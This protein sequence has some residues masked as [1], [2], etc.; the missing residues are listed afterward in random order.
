LPTPALADEILTPGEGQVR[1]LFCNGGN[2][3][4]AVPDQ[5]KLVTALKSLELLVVLD[6]RMTA[7]ARLAHY[8]F[9][10]KLSMEE[11]DYT[12][13]QEFFGHFPFAQYSPA[14]IQP[15]FDVIDEWE[16]FWGMAHR[17]RVPMSLG[18]SNLG[19]RPVPG[20]PV[21]IE[22]KP[23]TDELMEIEAG[24]ARIP[25]SQVKQYPG[26]QIFEEAWATVAPRG[27]DAAGRF[28]L[29]PGLFLEDLRRVHAEPVTSSGAYREDE[30]FTHRLISR[31]MREVYN[32][33]GVHLAAL[34][35]KGPGN[36]AY[37]NPDDMR[38]AGIKSG[39]MVEIESSHGRIVAIARAEDGLRKG[40][41]SMS[42]SWGDLPEYESQDAPQG[43][44]C[45]NR[46]I[47]DDSDFEP[48]VGM[49][50]QSA[51]PVNVRRPV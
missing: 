25:L 2:L 50:R 11:P 28:D 12:R 47:A 44:T 5:I 16:L 9:G 8:V 21:D 29:A 18:R 10:C 6:V 24:D 43:G 42:H 39:D 1:A 32:S 49:C 48:L 13:H 35:S 31:R 37:M 33:T 46:L 51:I 41:I 40:V 19:G 45:T 22:H 4:V 26:G 14:F 38:A 7:T 36:P 34:N 15:E 17:M 23:T 3:A 27:A 20:R 30:S